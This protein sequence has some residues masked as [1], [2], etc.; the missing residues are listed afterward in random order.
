MGSFRDVHDSANS[1]TSR[2]VPTEEAHY[3]EERY[4]LVELYRGD[5]RAVEI[6]GQFNASEA[7]M[8]TTL[9]KIMVLLHHSQK[10]L[11]ERNDRVTREL[12]Q[13]QVD[14]VVATHNSRSYLL[15]QTLAA[16]VNIFFGLMAAR[17]TAAKSLGLDRT[18]EALQG[19][20]SSNPNS[21]LQ[22][23]RMLS[24]QA[25]HWSTPITT[26]ATILDNRDQASRQAE[27]S[28][29]SLLETKHQTAGQISGKE[30]D[31]SKSNQQF[32]QRL[33]EQ[34]SQMVAAI[35]RN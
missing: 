12:I 17:P 23:S 4:E 21:V 3:N 11:I 9:A 15:F 25:Q 2:Q 26:L 5:K 20:K 8:A 34:R 10:N 19:L 35:L 27:M 1:S 29:K 7:Q 13:V 18:F 32:L 31:T 14:K 6:L 24:K 28:T 16:G 22:V 30:D 33:L